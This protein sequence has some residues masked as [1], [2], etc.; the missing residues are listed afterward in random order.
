MSITL[1]PKCRTILISKKRIKICITYTFYPS[2][3]DECVTGVSEMDAMELVATS[4]LYNRRLRRLLFGD[5]IEP[6]GIAST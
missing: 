5:S 1:V 6:G 4:V 2:L 3:A